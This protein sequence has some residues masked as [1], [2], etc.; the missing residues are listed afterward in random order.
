MITIRLV[1]SDE[2]AQ[3]EPMR[4]GILLKESSNRRDLQGFER[5]LAALPGCYAQPDGR[6]LLAVDGA[7]NAGCVALRPLSNGGCEMKRLYVRPSHRSQGIGRQLA[8]AIIEEARKIGYRKMKLDTISTMAEAIALYRSLGFRETEP[9][10]HN[11]IPGAVFF[12][13]GLKE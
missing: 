2:Q 4:G 7:E 5:E 9:Y 10:T 8:L 6:L 3:V 13:L 1:Q 11:P 12:S